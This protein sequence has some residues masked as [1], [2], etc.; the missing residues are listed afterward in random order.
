[1]LVVWVHYS[2]SPQS[3][4][5]I[6]HKLAYTTCLYTFISNH[7]F[8]IGVASGLLGVF[9]AFWLLGARFTISP[10]LVVNE[11]NK[12]LV[13]VR[14]DFFMFKVIDMT[15][16]MDFIRYERG[17]KDVRTQRIKL[18]KSN[19]SV[20]YG[21]CY[22]P[23]KCHYTFHTADPFIWNSKYDEIR[24]RVTGLMEISNI[25]RIKEVFYTP[26]QLKPGDFVDGKYVAQKCLYSTRT[27]QIWS[28]EIESMCKYVRNSNESVSR[29]IE[30]SSLADRQQ[31]LVDID[32]AYEQVKILQTSELK[33]LFPC[34]EENQDAVRTLLDELLKLRGLWTI[35][36]NMNPTN[37][38]LLEEIGKNIREYCF[39]LSK[40]LNSDISRAYK[41]E[42]KAL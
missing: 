34:L 16:E 39:Y 32:T 31:I 12:L 4:A 38:K 19:L 6:T 27:S 29:A 8:S 3:G 20:L 9:A 37:S 24:C 41:K 13:Q 25:K 2:I 35:V 18:N 28:K 21:R 10:E 14:N 1:M 33:E 36:H 42:K 23:S 15:I 22:G 17:G 11:N 26:Q 40:Q 7:P 30:Y 5:E